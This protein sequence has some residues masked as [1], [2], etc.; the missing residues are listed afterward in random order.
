M[1]SLPRNRAEIGASIFFSRNFA[2]VLPHCGTIIF[3]PVLYRQFHSILTALKYVFAE[4]SGG[5][6]RS[7]N[8][9]ERTKSGKKQTAKAHSGAVKRAFKAAAVA[10]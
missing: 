2:P 7:K 10:Q 9:I 6:N 8:A 3:D 4:G 1:G 5:W